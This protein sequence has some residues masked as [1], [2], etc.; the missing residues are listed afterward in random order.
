MK[1]LSRAT[2]IAFASLTFGI[3]FG[4]AAI[5]SLLVSSNPPF[6][7]PHLLATAVAAAPAMLVAFGVAAFWRPARA[8]LP[9]LLFLGGF[10]VPVDLAFL[11]LQGLFGEQTLRLIIGVLL[12]AAAAW[13][14]IPISGAQGRC[15][16]LG[17][18]KSSLK[19]R[20][21][22]VISK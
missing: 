7:V 9:P 18:R 4:C 10:T 3:L 20:V 2:W 22:P 14:S 17:E 1:P 8:G 11:C 19:V 12:V 16:F 21:E 13:V 5:G 15:L 6:F